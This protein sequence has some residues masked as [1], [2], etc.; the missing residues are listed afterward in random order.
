MIRDYQSAKEHLTD[1]EELLVLLH[2]LLS[3]AHK[4]TDLDAIYSDDGY[5]VEWR[6]AVRI[7]KKLKLKIYGDEPEPKIQ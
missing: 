3:T 4:T 2:V 6:D 1:D 5:S 7:F